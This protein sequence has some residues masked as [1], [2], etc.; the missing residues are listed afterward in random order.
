MFFFL[1]LR[2]RTSFITVFTLFYLFA[3]VRRS[4]RLLD[5]RDDVH[6]D[7]SGRAVVELAT[8]DVVRAVLPAPSHVTLALRH[9]EP[10]T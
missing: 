1:N 4:L 7:V 9:P 3:R 5:E 2:E 8:V 6:A 10:A